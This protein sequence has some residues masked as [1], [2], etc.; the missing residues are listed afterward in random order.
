[1]VSVTIPDIGISIAASLLKRLFVVNAMHLY[2]FINLTNLHSFFF[3]TSLYNHT[4]S[5]N[6]DIC[7]IE[8]YYMMLYMEI[9]STKSLAQGHK[10]LTCQSGSCDVILLV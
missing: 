7:E 10:S 2:N 5:F 6:S 4:H 3:L 1:M 9:C 8:K